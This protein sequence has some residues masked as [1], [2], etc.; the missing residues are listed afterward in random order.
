MSWL[1]DTSSPLDEI[2]EKATGEHQTTE[3]WE[4]IL[5]ICDAIKTDSKF[6][7]VCLRYFH[8]QW[9][10][11]VMQRISACDHVDKEAIEPSWSPC[12]TSRP[13]RPR[14]ML[15]QFRTYFQVWDSR[16]S[17][18]LVAKSMFYRLQLYLYSFQTGDFIT[19]VYQW[20]GVQV[21]KCESC[22][23]YRL[24]E[25]LC[26]VRTHSHSDELRLFRVK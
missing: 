26:L 21:Q 10:L 8:F 23:L 16:T 20:V 2:V 4:L 1:F 15:G 17:V 18:D 22:F 13:F 12:G 24:K 19:G 3:N 9:Y 25:W 11:A 14:F 6:V 7:K 5:H